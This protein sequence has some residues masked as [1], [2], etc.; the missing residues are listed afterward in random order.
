MKIAELPPITAVDRDDLFTEYTLVC[1]GC[2]ATFT[3]TNPRTGARCVECNAGLKA[4][5]VCPACDLTHVIPILAPTK[6]CGPCRVDLDMTA[7]ALRA[8]LAAADAAYTEACARLDVDLAHADPADQ[9]R[10]ATALD[11]EEA[12]GP[13]RFGRA[14]AA[15]IARGDGLSPLLRALLAQRAAN[16]AAGVVAAACWQGLAAVEEARTL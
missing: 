15:A 10:Y 2:G 6:L 7:A 13:E 3:T 5:V 9:A 1:G 11:Q 8:R 14:L 16:D 12:W 4:R